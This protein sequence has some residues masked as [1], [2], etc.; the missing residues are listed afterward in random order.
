M[1]DDEGFDNCWGQWPLN[2]FVM[3]LE[4]NSAAV[5]R[6]KA[7]AGELFYVELYTYWDLHSGQKHLYDCLVLFWACHTFVMVTCSV[8]ETIIEYQLKIEVEF[9]KKWSCLR[10]IEKMQVMVYSGMSTLSTCFLQF[11][12]KKMGGAKFYLVDPTQMQN[13]PLTYLKQKNYV[14]DGFRVLSLLILWM[15]VPLGFIFVGKTFVENEIFC[16]FMIK[17]ITGMKYN[18][19]KHKGFEKK[20]SLLKKQY[21]M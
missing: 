8:K 13:P 18:S 9:L 5:L 17:N 12:G 14:N 20:G 19:F 10:W 15:L 6:P 1:I 2:A 7:K 3:H 21:K 11:V 16:K 4:S